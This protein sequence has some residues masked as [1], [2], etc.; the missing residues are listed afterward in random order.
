MKIR[1]YLLVSISYLGLSSLAWADSYAD[2]N[3]FIF[4]HTSNNIHLNSQ[5]QLLSFP[6]FPKQTQAE[7]R[8]FSAPISLA[9]TD[10][11][12]ASVASV[13]FITDAGNCAGVGGAAIDEKPTSSGG[14][15]DWYLDTKQQ[16]INSGYDCTPCPDGQK[17]EGLCPFDKE[18]HVGCKTT[19]AAEFNKTCNGAD[20]TGKGEACGG[21]YKECCRICAEYPYTSG[22][23]PNGHV[24][25]ASCVDCN[26]QTKVQSKCDTNSGNNGKYMDCGNATG[27]GN[28][29][30]DDSGVYY[31]ECKCPTNYEFDAETKKCVCKTNF[32]YAC[33]GSGYAGGSGESCDNKYQTCD[34]AEGYQWS[35]TSGCVVCDNSFKYTCTG[36]NESKPAAGDCGG[37]YTQC[38]CASGYEWNGSA[39]VVACSA[40]YKYTCTGSNQS[41]G[42]G[43]ACGGYYTSCTCDSPYTW[44]SGTCQCPSN[45]TYTCTGTNQTGGSGT[46]CGG[47]YTKCS[48]K[49]PY[50]WTFGACQCPS[51][52]KYTC[53]GSNLSGGTGTACGGM[54]A[55]CKCTNAYL[56]YYW[57]NG[58]CIKKAP[59][60]SLCKIGALF[61]ADDSCSL[62]KR[63]EGVVLGV[64]IYEKTY[65]ENGL[66]LDKSETT[67]VRWGISGIRTLV[68]DTSAMASCSNTK[69]LLKLAETA[70]DITYSA[71]IAAYDNYYGKEWCLP[72]KGALINLLNDE[73]LYKINEGFRKIGAKIVGSHG[74]WTSSEH[75]KEYAYRLAVN[76]GGGSA[77]FSLWYKGDYDSYNAARSVFAF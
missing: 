39:C 6:I 49:S 15:D 64:V 52:Y 26:G 77:D 61:Y 32:K 67:G 54:Y 45:Y 75:G 10:G 69:K 57:N 40:D 2:E 36:A 71:A 4:T 33:T 60:Y 12:T 56:G 19:C 43:T 31:T 25:T 37:K 51:T 29:C 27:S 1:N 68:T 5:W 30:A 50:T 21:L 47:K 28:S 8:D 70:G 13:C 23:L 16:C 22:S 46:A 53:K 76:E 48:C 63:S 58:Q 73:Y 20:E 41:G 34:C 9:L 55:E 66:V 74:Y 17:P 7:Q 38:N 24:A 65:S 18:C 3:K 59:D 72:S 42:A 11:P 35:S 62:T 44:T 14:P